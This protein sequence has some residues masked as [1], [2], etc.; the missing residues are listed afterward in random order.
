MG[1]KILNYVLGM[2]G[3][4][5]YFFQAAVSYVTANPL[6]F[7]VVLLLLL[8]GNKSIQLGKVFKAKG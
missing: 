3:A 5:T 2:L 7:G 1:T 8:S 4:A 6:F